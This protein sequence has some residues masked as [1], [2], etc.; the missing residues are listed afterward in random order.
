M[1]NKTRLK[2]A[3]FYNTDVYKKYYTRTKKDK[4]YGE[5]PSVALSAYFKEC[6]DKGIVPSK[7][8]IESD[9]GI[10]YTTFRWY[11]EYQKFARE[12][13]KQPYVQA[14]RTVNIKEID[15]ELR[16]IARSSFITGF[17]QFCLLKTK[18]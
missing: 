7:K 11:P 12:H 3:I 2:K 16:K 1:A 10:S 9:I 14:K 17:L 13:H 18:G 15:K 4:P 5:T 6:A 8:Q